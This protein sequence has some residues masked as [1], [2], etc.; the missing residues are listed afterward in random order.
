MRFSNLPKPYTA[1]ELASLQLVLGETAERGRASSE[2]T[3]SAEDFLRSFESQGR[4]SLYGS[5]DAAQAAALERV[6][7]ASPAA[8]AA[9]LKLALVLEMLRMT[10]E[11]SLLKYPESIREQ[12]EIHLGLIRQAIE[13][14][15]DSYFRLDNDIYL[16]DLALCGGRMLPGGAQLFQ[17]FGGVPRSLLWTDGARQA[18]SFAFF[19][20]K[21]KAPTPLFDMHT[22]PRRMADF[23]SAGWDRFYLRVVE[24]LRQQ[25]E[26]RGLTGS[27]WWYDPAVPR[28][29]P[30]LEFLRETPLRYGAKTFRYSAD[31]GAK[32]S[33]LLRSPERQQAF[34]SGRYVPTTY[35][36]IWTRKDMFR[37]A[38]DY[39]R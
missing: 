28:L 32:L 39:V 2:V 17:T 6:R 35:I 4:P 18:L 26:I 33:A 3:F 5:V 38:D 19:L 13:S 36:L 31:E 9:Y 27:S 14:R 12:Y 37:W 25:P 1:P 30:Q 11:G 20:L 22:D 24:V 21:L 7:K 29:S 16:K 8:G 15:P 10:S 34:N 23:T